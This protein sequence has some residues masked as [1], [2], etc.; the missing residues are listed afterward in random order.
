MKIVINECF[1]GFG[2][3]KIARE[4]LGIGEYDSMKRTDL[5]LVSVVMALGSAAA[6]S[7][8]AKLAVVDV[9]DDVEWYIEEYDGYEH[10]AEKHRTW[11]SDGEDT[12]S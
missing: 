1:G 5:R 10:V 12:R 8:Y 7:M 3:S 9:P 2:L 11:T 4:E 6:S